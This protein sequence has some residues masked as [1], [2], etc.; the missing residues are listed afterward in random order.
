MLSLVAAAEFPSKGFVQG[1]R[2]F[3]KLAKAAVLLLV[4]KGV[5]DGLVS[6]LDLP[7]LSLWSAG[8]V[9]SF[10]C[11]PI[12]LRVMRI[13]CRSSRAQPCLS[14]AQPLLRLQWLQVGSRRRGSSSASRPCSRGGQAPVIS[15][16]HACCKRLLPP[17][18][19]TEG[20]LSLPR[21]A[22]TLETQSKPLGLSAGMAIP[23]LPVRRPQTAGRRSGQP[24]HRDPAHPGLRRRGGPAGVRRLVGDR[25]VR[26]SE[27]Y[28]YKNLLNL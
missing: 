14:S 18:V 19:F 27:K 9:P 23:G 4:L 21:S 15:P 6:G 10:K 5:A 11:A 22:C 13:S 1:F 25:P 7:P 8:A 12:G 24:A 26:N 2:K 17:R 20:C 16:L 28:L 3:A